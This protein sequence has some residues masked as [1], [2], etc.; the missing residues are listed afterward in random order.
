MKMPPALRSVDFL[1]I[2]LLSPSWG[3]GAE[4][5]SAGMVGSRRVYS[6]SAACVYILAVLWSFA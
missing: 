4:V 3:R 6:G 5:A 1:R 2:A